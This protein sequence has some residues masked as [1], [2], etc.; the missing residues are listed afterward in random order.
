MILGKMYIILFEIVSTYSAMCEIQ[1]KICVNISV[2]KFVCLL[3][4]RYRHTTRSI[5]LNSVSCYSFQWKYSNRFMVDFFGKYFLYESAICFKSVTR[6]VS[7][8]EYFR[9]TIFGFHLTNTKFTKSEHSQWN[10]CSE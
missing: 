6:N 9:V 1:L 2:L 7:D 4:S 10:H 3:S 5:A 8:C